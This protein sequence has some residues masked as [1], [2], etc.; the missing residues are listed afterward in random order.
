MPGARATTLGVSVSV[1]AAPP[2]RH[3]LTTRGA[4]PF[5]AASS[6]NYR[7]TLPSYVGAQLFP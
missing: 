7:P 4:D 5:A 1:T 6:E 3:G 2:D